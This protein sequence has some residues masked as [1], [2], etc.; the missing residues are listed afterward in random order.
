M[1]LIDELIRKMKVRFNNKNKYVIGDGCYYWKWVFPNDLF[2]YQE[3][4]LAEELKKS[5]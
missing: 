1:I 4:D 2:E 5:L 3:T